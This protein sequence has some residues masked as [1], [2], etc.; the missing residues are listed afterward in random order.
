MIDENFQPHDAHHFENDDRQAR[1]TL[2]L[3]ALFTLA[4]A[5]V[6]VAIGQRF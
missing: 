5:F 6:F 2:V 3:L 4:M 1:L